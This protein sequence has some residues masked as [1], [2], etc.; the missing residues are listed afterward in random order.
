MK[1]VRKKSSQK[2]SLFKNTC[3]GCKIPNTTNEIYC[4]D[5]CKKWDN[6]DYDLSR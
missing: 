3:K 6:I 4:S 2:T 1:N 5:F